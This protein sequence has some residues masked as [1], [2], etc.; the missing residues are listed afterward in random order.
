MNN[1]SITATDGTGTFSAYIATPA[2]TPAPAVIV[3]QEIFGINADMRA[4]CD[5]LAQQGYLAIAPDLFWRQEPGVDI[6]DKSEAEWAKAKALLNGFDLN[7]GVEDLNA[8]L[9]TIRKNPNNNDK[10]GCVG[11]C[12]GGRLAYLMAARTNIDASVSYYGI[13]LDTM[14]NES[15]NI[16]N[17]LLLHVAELDKFVPPMARDA[18][19]NHFKNSQI[20]TSHLY[21]DVDHA[22]S[23][24]KGEHY[25]EAAAILANTR[26]AAFFEQHLK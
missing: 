6:T 26:T 21:K 3:I 24:Y 12:L 19:L 15:P 7:K 4:K 2:Q 9:E 1:I 11:Y 17:P 10:V 22:F 23:R 25:N 13:A 20:V 16:K 5:A 14:L 18:V 8:T